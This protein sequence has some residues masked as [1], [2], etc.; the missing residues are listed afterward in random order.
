MPH[1]RTSFSHDPNCPDDDSAWRA[2]TARDACFDGRIYYAVTT[3][4]IYCRPSCPARKPDRANVTFHASPE[5]AERAGFRPCKRCDPS[6]AAP[7]WAE[8]IEQACRLMELA[9]A[10]PTLAA[11]ADAV[12]SSPHHF[13]RQFKEFL[14]ITPKAYAAALRDD[15][16]RAALSRGASVTHALYEAGFSSSGRFYAG[17]SDA[18]GMAPRTFRDGGTAEQ[19]TYAVAPCSL[20]HVLVAA[21]AK[22]VCAI[23]LGDRPDELTEALQTLFPRATFNEGDDWFGDTTAAVVCFGRRARKA[24]RAPARYSRHGIPTARVGGVA[25]NSARQ[26]RD[27]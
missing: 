5:A 25:Q 1:G 20:G 9:E 21:S 6:A 8:K 2:V 27:L 24:E 22:G 26:D 10:P 16:V 7:A 23:I 12:G 4:G 17:A 3:T 14:G 19:L 13:H 18:L 11:L 15:R